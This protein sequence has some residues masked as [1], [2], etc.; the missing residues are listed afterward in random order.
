MKVLKYKDTHHRGAFNR[1]EFVD[2]GRGLHS[3]PFPLNLSDLA[4]CPLN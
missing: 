4:P 2:M 1:L 3:F